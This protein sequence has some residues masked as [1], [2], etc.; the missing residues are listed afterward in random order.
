[1]ISKDYY[2][3]TLGIYNVCSKRK[4]VAVNTRYNDSL[5]L[6]GRYFNLKVFGGSSYLLGLELP[7]MM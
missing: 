7:V 5:I 2:K 3:S 1:M 6:K 4:L